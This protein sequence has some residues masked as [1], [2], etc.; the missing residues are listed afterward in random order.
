MV[1][2][3]EKIS[4]KSGYGEQISQEEASTGGTTLMYQTGNI[5]TAHTTST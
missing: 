2:R 5:W 3:I 4:L 1:S